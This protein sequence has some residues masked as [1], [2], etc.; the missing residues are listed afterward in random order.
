LGELARLRD[1]VLEQWGDDPLSA[2][3]E[4]TLDRREAEI[5]QRASTQI[6][7]PFPVEAAGV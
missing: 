3:L 4:A 7:L 6:P 2:E 5:T 1:F